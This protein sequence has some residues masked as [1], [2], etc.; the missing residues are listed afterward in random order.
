MVPP[1]TG[2]E[3]TGIG[4]RFGMVNV[5]KGRVYWYATLNVPETYT[6]PRPMIPFLRETFAAFA[7]P[8]SSLID[9]TP[10]T[11]CIYTPCYDRVP[12]H[13]WR[14][15]SSILIGDAAHPSTPNLGQGACQA[16][17]DGYVLADTLEEHENLD[18]ALDAF[19]A[20]RFRR[21]AWIQ[22]RSYQFGVI[23]QWASPPLVF[24]RDWM[25]RLTP[26]SVYERQY[27]ELFGGGP[28]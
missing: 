3:R 4:R 19:V 24:F 9:A 16:I 22:T 27:R 5:G 8:V 14:G 25:T 17:E 7:K 18:E 23:G 6:P 21:T 13:D 1:G 10:D 11:S 20:A 28:A 26:D 2:C 12:S 15:P